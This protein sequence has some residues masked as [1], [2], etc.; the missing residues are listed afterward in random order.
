MDVWKKMSAEEQGMYEAA[1]Q[2]S[3]AWTLSYAPSAQTPQIEEFEAGG[4]IVKRFPETR[5]WPIYVSQPIVCCK[6]KSKKTHC[7]AKPTIR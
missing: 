7:T 4:S 3:I 5:D 2:V 6:V 1:C